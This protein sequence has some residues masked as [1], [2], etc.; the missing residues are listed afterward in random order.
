[1]MLGL[2]RQPM[3]ITIHSYHTMCDTL[4][5]MGN[6]HGL[7]VAAPLYVTGSNLLVATLPIS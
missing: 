5:H 1:M 2:R 6:S 7:V 3:I 4:R